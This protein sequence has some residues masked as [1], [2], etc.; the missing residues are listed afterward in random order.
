MLPVTTWLISDFGVNGGHELRT[1]R[2]E[3]SGET[4]FPRTFR[5]AVNELMELKQ[6]RHILCG[7]VKVE[8]AD[9]PDFA[10][11]HLGKDGRTRRTLFVAERRNNGGSLQSIRSGALWASSIIPVFGLAEA[12]AK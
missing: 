3:E 5:S 12:E 8:T 1:K 6:S 7:A 4:R 11:V 10:L 2:I 9:D